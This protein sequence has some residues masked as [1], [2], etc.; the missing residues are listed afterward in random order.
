MKLT[1]LLPYAK[2]VGVLALLWAGLWAFN[3]KGCRRI[4]GAEM[5]PTFAADKM[6]LIAPRVRH[7]SQ[8]ERGD[9]VSYT[10]NIG[11]GTKNVAARVIGLPGDRV[12]IEKGVVYL[13][14]AALAAESVAANN[15]SDDDY[16]E[17]IVPRD[18]V[19]V[20][21]DNRKQGLT[22]DSRALGPVSAWAINGRF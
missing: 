19:F 8:L 5:A 17:I 13:N 2:V 15:R 3:N 20:L 11:R 9:V 22:L 10:A 18:S 12:R 21:C 14:G 16:A 1:A 7:P 6:K 4:E